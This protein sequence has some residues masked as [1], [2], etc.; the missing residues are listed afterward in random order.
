MRVLMVILVL[1]ALVA[2]PGRVPADEP[3][4]EPTAEEIVRDQVEALHD[5]EQAETD[6]EADAA[7]ERFD[8]A[9]SLELRRR[10]AVVDDLIERGGTPAPSTR[11]SDGRP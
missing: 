6:E 4:D 7:E 5:L 10:R 1:G 11:P 3:D 8:D 2:G 9:A